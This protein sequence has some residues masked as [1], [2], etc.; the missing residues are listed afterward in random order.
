MQC[1]CGSWGA[2]DRDCP[3]SL[4]LAPGKL[5][6]G[7]VQ[8]ACVQRVVHASA[9]RHCSRLCPYRSLPAWHARHLLDRGYAD[10]LIELLHVHSVWHRRCQVA[11]QPLLPMHHESAVL[12][13]CGRPCPCAQCKRFVVSADSCTLRHALVLM[14]NRSMTD[15]R[16]NF[17]GTETVLDFM[18]ACRAAHVVVLLFAVMQP[19]LHSGAGQA[20]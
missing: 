16:Y 5:P 19:V 12:R 11:S 13:Q 20:A 17:R 9:T 7:N 18:S 4:H 6:A 8:A 14:L 2:L 10:T 1:A 3:A 15:Q